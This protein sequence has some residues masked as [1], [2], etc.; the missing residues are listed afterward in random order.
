[1]KIHFRSYIYV[2]YHFGDSISD[3]EHFSETIV[4]RTDLYLV[5]ALRFTNSF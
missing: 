4:G 3:E 2:T 1:M 5:K